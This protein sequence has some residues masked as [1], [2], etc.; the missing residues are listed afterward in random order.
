M[1]IP[2]PGYEFFQ[3][4]IQ[5]QK[6]PWIPDSPPA[7]RNLSI[8]TRKIVSKLPEY[9]PGCSSRIR[10]RKYDPGCSSQI[11]ILIFY[12]SRILDP[13][14][15]KAPNPGSGSATLLYFYSYLIKDKSQ[16]LIYPMFGITFCLFFEKHQ[17]NP[18]VLQVFSFLIYLFG[19]L[20]CVG[21]S[22]AYVAFF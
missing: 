19:G 4:R 21:H 14:V 3:S 13:G 8:L 5:G 11:R 22:F 12:P 18:L 15:E 6:D 17:I 1:F 2:D 7:S 20:E 10:T 9:D 16:N